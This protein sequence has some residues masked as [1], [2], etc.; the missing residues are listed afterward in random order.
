MYQII[1]EVM[2]LSVHLNKREKTIK[3]HIMYKTT[4]SRLKYTHTDTQTYIHSLIRILIHAFIY[5]VYMRINPD[6]CYCA[7]IHFKIVANTMTSTKAT[8]TTATKL[9]HISFI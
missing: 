6:P 4:P 2:M 3:I 5:C 1:N 7:S 9:T 8:T